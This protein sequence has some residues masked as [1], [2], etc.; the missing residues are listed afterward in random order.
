MRLRGRTSSGERERRSL[1]SRLDAAMGEV[2]S[3]RER[4]DAVEAQA[5]VRERELGEAAG[6][7]TIDDATHA[8]QLA[9]VEANVQAAADRLGRAEAAAEGVRA[10]G[11][12]VACRLAD[13]LRSEARAAAAGATER[14]MELREQL[15]AAQRL[16]DEAEEAIVLVEEDAHQLVEPFAD[17]EE[18]R[19][20]EIRR[21]QIRE[22]V[23]W[24][25]RNPGS[26]VPA[27]LRE[28]V[29]EARARIN[30][31]RDEENAARRDLAARQQAA[32]ARGEAKD[33]HELIAEDAERRKQQ[34][35]PSDTQ[36]RG[37]ERV[38]AGR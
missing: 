24:Y 28:Q 38:P 35:A 7:G 8:A 14:V 34:A 9:E 11:R 17:R 21:R 18:R 4:L 33:V 12:E 20:R 22:R 37:F 36:A 3:A 26:E 29:A 23:E 30:R 13:D 32:M 10:K 5:R 16:A 25:A 1:L 6:L 27:Q 15:V 19:A 2:E 31:Q